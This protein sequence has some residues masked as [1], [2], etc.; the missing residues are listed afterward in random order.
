MTN[1][2][3]QREMLSLMTARVRDTF[4]RKPPVLDGALDLVSA[5]RELAAQRATAALVRDAQG[6]VERLGIFTTTDLRDALLHDLPPQQLPLRAAA[7]FDLIEVQADAEV[8]EALWLMVH[9]QV[10]RVL[11]RDGQRVLGLLGQLDLVSFV[12]NHSYLAAQQIEHAQGVADLGAAARR[13][14]EMIGLLHGSGVRVERIARIVTELNRRL[15]ARLW[16]LLAPPELAA[17]SCLLVM[18]SEG[19]GEQILKT[20]QDNALLLRDGFEFEGLNG[21]ATHFAAALAEFGYPPCPGGIMVT[22]A[23]WRQPLSSFRESLRQ[24][25]YGHDPEGPMNLAIFFDAAAVAG[26][27]R[28]LEAARD[29]LDSLLTGQDQ[30]LARFAAAADQFREP[31][32]FWSRLTGGRK[33]RDETP[34]DLKKLGTFPIVH[35]VRALALQYHVR[36]AGTSARLQALQAAGRIDEA[37]ARDLLDALHFLMSLRLTH[38]LRQRAGGA[39]PGNEV[40]PSELGALEREPLHDALAIVKRFR[41]FLRQH[42]HLDRL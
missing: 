10:H 16:S 41:G 26:D 22:S 24:W 3:S 35:G 5:C 1:T 17:N 33:G 4:V 39:L 18:G 21:V 31:G 14:D 40:R 9:H 25:L 11:V 8:F 12:A 19:R 6:G 23:R 2:D 13:I 38:Q 28:L 30:Y 42:F 36:E 15:F 20:D 34:L 37:L 27:G 7:R 32:N 29:H